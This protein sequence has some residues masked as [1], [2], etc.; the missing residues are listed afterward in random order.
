[1]ASDIIHAEGVRFAV[2]SSA[3]PAR[4]LLSSRHALVQPISQTGSCCGA[5]SPVICPAANGLAQ[6]QKRTRPGVVLGHF[7][8]AKYGNFSRVPTE[9]IET[10]C[11][12]PYEL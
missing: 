12:Q 2:P 6:R 9:G 1:M 7:C 10:G 3:P 8:R 4:N 5:G 11:K